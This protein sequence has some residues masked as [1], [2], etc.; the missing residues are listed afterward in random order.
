LYKIRPWTNS[1]Q[2]R[3]LQAV[4]CFATFFISH[5]M[6]SGYPTMSPE[7]SSRDLQVLD[8]NTTSL[9]LNCSKQHQSQCPVESNTIVNSHRLSTLRCTGHQK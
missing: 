1:H 4:D 7:T 9:G 6:T 3:L 5:F 8:V 2:R